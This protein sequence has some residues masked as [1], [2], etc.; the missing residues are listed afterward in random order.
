MSFFEPAPPPPPQPPR[1][2]APPL[3]DRPSEGTVPA[4]V[5]VDEIVHRSADSVAQL[6]SLRV[7]PNGFVVNLF[8]LTDP[9]AGDAHRI[10][11]M[12]GPDPMRSFPL[13][14]VRFADGRTA[15]R[16]GAAPF[17]MADIPRDAEGIPTEPV[18]RMTGGGGGSNGFHFSVWVHP[19]PPGGPLE[20]HVA[21]PGAD[22]E[23][24]VVLDGAAVR[25]A[26]E[27]AVV[28]WS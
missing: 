11:M 5:P 28:V 1:Q 24:T 18:L 27:R 8:I 12:R 26:A 6:E 23:A 16:T 2:W 4:T 19:L 7:Y 14:G 17:G 25:A 10:A 15:G 9:H 13:I 3:W 22:R 21:M 20:I